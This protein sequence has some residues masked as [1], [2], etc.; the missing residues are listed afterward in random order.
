MHAVAPMQAATPLQRD[1]LTPG[2]AWVAKL[3]C[4]TQV[5]LPGPY[6]VGAGDGIADIPGVGIQLLEIRAQGLQP[7]YVMQWVTKGDIFA[8]QFFQCVEVSPIELAKRS[9]N[10][11]RYADMLGS[12]Q[13]CTKWV[14]CTGI[15]ETQALI[16]TARRSCIG[17][18]QPSVWPSCPRSSATSASSSRTFS[19]ANICAV[20]SR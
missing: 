15:A 12:R 20:T 11:C 10:C 14:C 19:S 9:A 13:S 6:L 5:A 4:P 2:Q 8:V 3:Q 16:Y 7:L 18:C 1:R 17:F